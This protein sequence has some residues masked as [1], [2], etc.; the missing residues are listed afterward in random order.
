MPVWH[1]KVGIDGWVNSTSEALQ[2]QKALE[3]YHLELV[4]LEDQLHL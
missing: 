4:N 3:K 1:L 2:L